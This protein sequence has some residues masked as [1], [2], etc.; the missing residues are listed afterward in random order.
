M[1]GRPL[2]EPVDDL[3]AAGGAPRPS[4]ILADDFVAHGYDL[5]RLIR[6][7]AATE[8][9][10]LDSAG[11]RTSGDDVTDEGLGRLPDDP[12]PARA[13]RRRR[14]SRRPR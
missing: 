1:F 5:H 13:G 3:A 8:V 4:T 6:V 9:F 12:A 10:R 2:V 7:I 14:C 11:R